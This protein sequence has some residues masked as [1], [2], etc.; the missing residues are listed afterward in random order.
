MKRVGC[1]R[2]GARSDFTDLERGRTR[3]LSG[4]GRWVRPT[5]ESQRQFRFGGCFLALACRI[6]TPRL[7]RRGRSRSRRQHRQ[8]GARVH[9]PSR[10]ISSDPIRPVSA[11]LRVPLPWSVARAPHLYN[12]GQVGFRYGPK[13]NWSNLSLTVTKGH[14]T[15]VIQVEGFANFDLA[16]V[17]G[18]CQFVIPTGTRG[19]PRCHS[20]PS[21]R[22]PSLSSRT[23]R[24]AQG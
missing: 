17:A 12:G 13:G 15:P 22:P 18:A 16:T 20:D 8:W 3:K 10:D 23:E 24:E 14:L 21:T 2:G 11:S 5:T 7:A 6:E 1:V 9:P 4:W 19:V